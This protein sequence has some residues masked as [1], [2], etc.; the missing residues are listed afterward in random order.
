VDFELSD[1]QA[2]LAEA[3]RGL[4]DDLAGPDRVRAAADAGGFDR[5]LWGAMVDQG[6][7]AV[8]VPEEDGGLG[9]GAVEAAVLAEQ[10]GAHL[11]PTPLLPTVLALEAL[12]RADAEGVAGVARF[13]E[14]LTGGEQAGCVAW[15]ARPDAVVAR[16]EQ[17]RERGR[18]GGSARLT[19]RPDPTPFAPEASVAVVAATG[20]ASGLYAIDLDA[21]GRPDPQP[22]MDRT[23]PVGWLELDDTPAVR[24]G[25][26]AAVD[27]L[28]DR[29][30]ALVSVEMLGGAARVLDMAVEYAKERVQFGRPIGSFQAV[31]HRCADMLV[32]VE[33]MRSTAYWAAWCVAA[34]NE[35]RSIAASTAKTWCADASRRVM[36]SGL[37]VHGGIGFT[38]EHD[39]HLF[40]KRAQLDQQLFGDAVFHRR[41]LASLLRPK[42][43]AGESVV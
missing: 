29:G 14:L 38:W 4:L 22:A 8:M 6:W 20:E 3:A 32:D 11:A 33:G 31:K 21:I 17:G 42:V 19:G 10:A 37:Q 18:E 30:A 2:A 15:S 23:R 13:V 16:H 35:E 28:L 39:L 1:D 36:A 5:E 24:L 43:E 34:D 12:R 25:G 7:T 26:G 40:L 27:E 9:L 41:R